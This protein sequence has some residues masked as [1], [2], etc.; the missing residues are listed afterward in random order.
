MSQ[1]ANEIDIKGFDPEGEPVIQ[2]ISDGSLQIVFNFMPPSYVDDDEAMGD[3]DD[4]DK[5]IQAA[6]GVPVMWEDREIFVVETPENDTIDR[7]KSFLEN[8]RDN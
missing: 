4:F 6:I 8:Y 2:K 5:Q 1:Q 3:F 7:L